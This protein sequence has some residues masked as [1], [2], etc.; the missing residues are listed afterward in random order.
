VPLPFAVST[1]CSPLK[2]LSNCKFIALAPFVIVSTSVVVLKL[3]EAPN[4]SCCHS[5]VEVLDYRM[6]ALQITY[7]AVAPGCEILPAN[8]RLREG[9]FDGNCGQHRGLVRL[10]K[11]GGQSAHASKKEKVRRLRQLLLG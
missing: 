1:K 5:Q 3:P 7:G 9:S 6:Y 8:T 4:N 11:D 2:G 10:G